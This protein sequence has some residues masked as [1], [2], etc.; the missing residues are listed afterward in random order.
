M[1]QAIRRKHNRRIDFGRFMT[2]GFCLCISLLTTGC[3][4]MKE[5]QDR[6][7]VLVAAIDD[8][9]ILEKSTVEKEIA[10][11]QTFVQK[12][13]K[14]DYLLSLQILKLVKNESKEGAGQ[15]E[16]TFVIS[17]TGRSIFEMVRDMLGQSSKTLYF[18]HLQ[19]VIISEAALKKNG[20]RPLLDFFRRDPEMRS[21]TK[22]FITSGEARKIVEYSPPTGEPGGKYLEGVVRNHKK[23]IH[24]PG[25]KTDVGFTTQAL[26]NDTDFPLPRIEFVDNVSKIGG[27]A[28]FR[29]NNL[30]GYADEYITRGIK[31]IFGTE[32][33]AVIP[34]KCPDHQQPGIVYELFHHDTK[35]TPH[36][37]NEQA[38]FTLDITM[39]GNIGEINCQ[40]KHDMH[41]MAFLHR[42]EEE[43]AKEVEQNVQDA[44]AYQQQ[45]GVD[46]VNTKGRLKGA[47]PFD[48]KKI[49]DRWEDIFPTI[50]V[51][52]SVNVKIRGVGEHD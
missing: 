36:I 50:P 35:L 25:A 51:I 24:L 16:R 45:L 26:D 32:K 47:H 29:K 10:Q 1:V 28:L 14:K 48:W 9:D 52:V 3:W 37:E 46:I 44:W 23:D 40:T 33:S 39:E 6:N 41:D 4:D 19:A 43:I 20:I 15:A 49:Q 38:Y 8:A 13:G 31:F 22:V 27:A 30:M 42:I 21:R 2:L 34:V 11:T 18:E 12:E 5:L 17:N 7:F